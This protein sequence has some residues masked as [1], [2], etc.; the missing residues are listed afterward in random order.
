MP[1]NSKLTAE[2]QGLAVFTD[3]TGVV[4]NKTR[5]AK[6]RDLIAQEQTQLHRGHLDQIS[7]VA[8]LQLIKELDYLESIIVNV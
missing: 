4:T 1:L 3:Y 6:L 7:P 5:V 8:Q 2:L